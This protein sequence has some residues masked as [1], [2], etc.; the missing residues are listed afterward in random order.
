MGSSLCLCIGSS[1]D[2]SLS[3][4]GL[5]TRGGS[6]VTLGAVTSGAGLSIFF[7]LF[8]Y[9]SLS[10]NARSKSLFNPR[11]SDRCLSTNFHSWVFCA[12]A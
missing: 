7:S 11:I 5:A 4:D 3:D 9:R 12:A 6:A 2:S 8:R 1:T 10:S